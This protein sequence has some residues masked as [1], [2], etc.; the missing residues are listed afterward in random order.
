MISSKPSPLTSP[1][2]DTLD[3]RLVDSRLALDDEALVGGERAE[4]DGCRSA[5]DHGRTP[6]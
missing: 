4:V 6:T 2:E 5:A 3:A 1:A